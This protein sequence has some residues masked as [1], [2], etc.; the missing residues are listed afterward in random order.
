MK[1]IQPKDKGL[2]FPCTAMGLYTGINMHS[3]YCKHLQLQL[4]GPLAGQGETAFFQ[5]LNS[6]VLND[7]EIACNKPF[8]LS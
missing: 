6:A 4:R 7:G 3:Q 2:T 1:Y 5:H 8:I